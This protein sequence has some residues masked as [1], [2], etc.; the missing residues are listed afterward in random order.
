MKSSVIH[1][2]SDSRNWPRSSECVY[3]GEIKFKVNESMD[4]LALLSWVTETGTMVLRNT[5][6][7]TAICICIC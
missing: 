6:N 2:R 1:P 7:D 3:V 5:A 4:L